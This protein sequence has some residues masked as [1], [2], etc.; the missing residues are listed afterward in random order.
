MLQPLEI[1]R[2]SDELKSPSMSRGFRFEGAS[3]RH[4]NES[5]RSE[6]VK[7]IIVEHVCGKTLYNL[8]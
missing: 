8:W 2:P 5:R 6:K 4:P 1:D 3:L 7:C